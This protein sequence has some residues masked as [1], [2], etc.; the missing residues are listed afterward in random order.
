MRL[1]KFTKSSQV[2]AAK[3]FKPADMV[4]YPAKGR[5]IYIEAVVDEIRGSRIICANKAGYYY[6]VSSG[7]IYIRQKACWI[8]QGKKYV[9]PECGHKN[10]A[11]TKFCP[12]CGHK[13]D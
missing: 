8:R 5:K 1:L 10:P 9:C 12:E 6:T 3:Q 11:G 13:K 2:R 7:E 4:D